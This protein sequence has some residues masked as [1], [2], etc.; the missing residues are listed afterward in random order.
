[1]DESQGK[2]KGQ[3]DRQTEE[4]IE[5][6]WTR[7]AKEKGDRWTRAREGERGQLDARKKEE[8]GDSWTGN[9]GRE[10]G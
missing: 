9:R 10:R 4:E 8:E 3:L 2:R 6:R 5:E 1:M 7:E